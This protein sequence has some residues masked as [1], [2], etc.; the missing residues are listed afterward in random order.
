MERNL[1]NRREEE[2]QDPLREAAHRGPEGEREA[3]GLDAKGELRIGS[4]TVKE[5]GAQMTGLLREVERQTRMDRVDPRR[6]LEEQTQ[7]VE[8]NAEARRP[9]EGRRKAITRKGLL[10]RPTKGGMDLRDARR[11]RLANLRGSPLLVDRPKAELE[12]RHRLRSG[13]P[14]WRRRTPSTATVRWQDFQ[15]VS[16]MQWRPR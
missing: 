5:R 2:S 16:G 3:H 4:W 10:T 8:Q 1:P 9:R 14:R 6:Q 15:E 13:T 7:L 11:R 12:S